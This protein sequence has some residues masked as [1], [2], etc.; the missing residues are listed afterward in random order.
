MEWFGGL[1][2]GENLYGMM[3]CRREAA[4]A[5][6]SIFETFLLSTNSPSTQQSCQCKAHAVRLSAINSDCE[7]SKSTNPH[8][9]YAIC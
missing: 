4:S 3:R 1:E 7:S 9:G 8:W 5:K 2:G 6:A